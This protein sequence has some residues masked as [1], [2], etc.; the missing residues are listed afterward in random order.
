[1]STCLAK[2]WAN[3]LAKLLTNLSTAYT[4]T[5]LY[6]ESISLSIWF[7]SYFISDIYHFPFYFISDIY[8]SPLQSFLSSQYPSPNISKLHNHSI[9]LSQP[10]NLA[11]I[12]SSL[13]IIILYVSAYICAF[14]KI[15]ANDL[16]SLCSLWTKNGRRVG[17]KSFIRLVLLRLSWLALLP[18]EPMRARPTMIHF[19]PLCFGY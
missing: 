1:M 9:F 4:C 8:H 14:I 19:F 13:C 2:E 16:L 10:R 5:T 15:C 11:H 6:I 7:R 18:S 17:K 3:H 12:Y